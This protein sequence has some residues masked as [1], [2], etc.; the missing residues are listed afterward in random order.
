[1]YPFL[2]LRNRCKNP[3]TCQGIKIFL[4]QGYHIHG[5]YCGL[6]YSSHVKEYFWNFKSFFWKKIA[7]IFNNSPTLSLKQIPKL[8]KETSLSKGLAFQVYQELA[9]IVFKHGYNLWV[10]WCWINVIQILIFIFSLVEISFI[11]LVCV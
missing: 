9:L 8:S 11:F 1:M 3:Q 7:K 5:Y 10:I 4:K 6:W 2:F